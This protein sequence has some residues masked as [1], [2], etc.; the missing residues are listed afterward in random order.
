MKSQ[1]RRDQVLDAAIDLLAEEGLRRLTHRALDARAGLPSGSTSNY[2][3]TRDVLLQGV[4]TALLDQERVLLTQLMG[5]PRPLDLSDLAGAVTAM[6]Q[7]LLGAGRR[8]TL[9]RFALL[10]EAV[11]QPAIRDGLR[12]G[13]ESL[14]DLGAA[15]LRQVGSPSPDE[16]ARLLLAY[17]DGLLADQLLMPRSS[18]D[19]ESAI[20][21]FLEGLA[22]VPQARKRKGRV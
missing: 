13:K 7:H 10:A 21:F 19:I 22:L 2:F 17:I 18:L 3:R 8:L 1:D 16:H 15:W 6:V 9:A 20:S 4:L 11:A 14:R 5:S 12:H